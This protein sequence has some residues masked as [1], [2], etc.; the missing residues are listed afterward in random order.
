M[1]Q[2]NYQ[3]T[4]A[5]DKA[6]LVEAQI[7][8]EIDN[9]RYIITKEK[10]KIISALGAIVKDSG[11][12]RLIHDCSRPPGNALNDLATCEKFSY[13]SVQDA[14]SLITPGCWMYKADLA[15]A[16]RSVKLHPN[17]HAISGLEWTFKGDLSPTWM[18]DSRLM[19]GARLSPS[20]FN[21]LSQAVRRIMAIKGFPKCIAYL[22]D[23]LLIA[24]TK[25]ECSRQALELIKLLRYLGF[26]INYNK[27]VGPAQCIT[28][29][30]VML[31]SINC[32][33]SLP[34]EKL[35]I[36]LQQVE[37]FNQRKSVSKKQLQ[38]L[39]GKLSWASQV[40]QGGRPHLRRILDCINLLQAPSHRTRITKD[41][42]LD[43][44]WWL[45]FSVHFNGTLPMIDNRPYAPLCIDACPQGG[46]GHFAGQAFNVQWSDWPGAAT[47]HINYLE[48]LALEPAAHLWAPE[49]A[50][51]IIKVHTDNQAACAIINRGTARN[52]FVMDSLRRVFW[53][54]A[55]YNFKISAVYY[56]GDHNVIAD[57]FSRIH[58]PAAWK[59]INSFCSGLM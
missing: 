29:L 27:V 45:S 23:F 34:K 57:A 16:Y 59:I 40:I 15:R 51:K 36:F 13:Q 53:L 20:I 6:P 19:F 30:G 43:F 7:R 11:K 32:T 2:A 17:E 14:V 8:E 21:E 44:S 42:R 5:P 37:D 33:L 9:G 47:L 38:S 39:A 25:E 55:I 18:Y 58:E 41:M 10:P 4:T 52:P 26:S 46:G 35:D 28:F 3:S 31:D 1:W 12:V 24:D 50:N 49:W 22:D 48:V 54:S 56:P